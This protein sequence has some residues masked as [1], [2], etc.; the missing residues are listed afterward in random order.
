GWMHDTLQYLA[1]DPIH[2]RHH[3]NEL[4]MRG[5]YAHTEA[6]VLPMSHDEVVHGKSS[7][8]GKMAGDR[9]QKFANLRLL[10]S[11]M[12][13]QPGKKLLFMGSELAPWTEWNHDDSLPW[14][15]LAEPA[16][17][18]VSLLVG[19]LNQLYRTERSLHELDCERAGIR[20]IDADDA[21]RSVLL[22][23]RIAR[24]PDDRTIIVLNFT[25]V[26]RYNYRVGV[27]APG[28]YDEVLNTVSVEFGGSGVGNLG[29]VETSPARAHRRDHSIALTLPPLGALFLRKR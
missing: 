15:L 8:L 27:P 21:E 22:Y 16:H 23:E 1:R 5:M 3:H 17:R 19:T 9:W 18:Q 10:Y 28:S 13:S 4:Q 24:D 2:R 7:L 6:F 11:Y 29:S 25:P 12:Y 14:H 26:P 20:W